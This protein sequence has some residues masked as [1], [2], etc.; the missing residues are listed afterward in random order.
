M[1]KRLFITIAA[2]SVMT[3]A[4]LAEDYIDL[5]RL[6]NEALNASDYKKAQEYYQKAETQ[7]PESPALDYNL[8]GALYHQGNYEETVER[9]QSALNTTDP[10]LEAQA[11][12]NLG[13]TYFRMQDYQKA[14]ESFQEALKSNPDD[15]DA[16]FNLELAR[17]MLK[18][19]SKPEQQEN[20]EQQQQQQEQQKQD[21]QNQGEEEQEEQQQDSQQQQDQQDQQDQDE[22]QKQQSKPDDKKMSKED[23]ERILNALRD[24]EQDIQ[25]KIKR[26][27]A[28]GTYKGK[29]W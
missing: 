17:K 23:A 1:L 11:Q 13:N 26:Q 10:N 20:Q 6:G 15:M 22:Q 5:V 16:K 4:S 3:G 14:I 7:I 19:H 12:Y 24:D 25:D 9:Y 8:A 2:M 27:V 29:D 28:L 18:E 21:E